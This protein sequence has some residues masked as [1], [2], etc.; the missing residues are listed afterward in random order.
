MVLALS[1]LFAHRLRAAKGEITSEKCKNYSSVPVYLF[2]VQALHLQ[3][4]VLDG[5]AGGSD[6]LLAETDLPCLCSARV[7]L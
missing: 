3:R 4:C 5:G 7:H 2:P 6:C 1:M